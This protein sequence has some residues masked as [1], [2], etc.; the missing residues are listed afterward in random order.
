MRADPVGVE[1]LLLEVHAVGPDAVA[2][3]QALVDRFV[4]GA[5]ALLAA[6]GVDDG[7]A[8]ATT[9]GTGGRRGP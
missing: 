6:P 7:T 4:G 8:R 5:T 3:L 9:G 1:M 2:L